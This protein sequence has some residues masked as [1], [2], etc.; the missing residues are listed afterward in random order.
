M[1]QEKIEVELRYYYDATNNSQIIDLVLVA[2]KTLPAWEFRS[3]FGKSKIHS[4]NGRRRL[5]LYYTAR[6]Q[7]GSYICRF[8]KYAGSEVRTYFVV[9]EKGKI[10]LME[11]PFNTKQEFDQ[12]FNDLTTSE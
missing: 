9:T 2:E 6:I 11:I 8:E 10:Q 5:D 3:D 7:S 1:S 12:F 4:I